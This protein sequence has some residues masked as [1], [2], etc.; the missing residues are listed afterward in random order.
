MRMSAILN[1]GVDSKAALD[2]ILYL[3]AIPPNNFPIWAGDRGW[4][5]G[6]LVG[7]WLISIS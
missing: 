3:G 5:V 7:W 1:F 6:G 4:L 2:F